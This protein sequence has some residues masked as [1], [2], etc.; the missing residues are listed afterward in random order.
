MIPGKD[1]LKELYHYGRLYC[2]SSITGDDISDCYG[3]ETSEDCQESGWVKPCRGNNNIEV[4]QVHNQKEN[5]DEA[6]LLCDESVV[7]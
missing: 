2:S 1:M 4:V 7:G 5:K 6:V 3:S